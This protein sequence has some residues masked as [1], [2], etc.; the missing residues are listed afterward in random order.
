MQVFPDGQ[1]CVDVNG[2]IAGSATSII[3]SLKPEYRSHSLYE[4][5]GSGH[6]PNG[7]SLYV[8][9]ILT[10]P[11]YRRRG[12]G[13]ALMNARKDLCIKF[14]LRRIIGGGRLS[15]YCNFSNTMSAEKYANLVVIK[16][17][18]DPVLSFD[19]KNGFKFIKILPNY[20]ADQRLLNFASF[21]E[22][23]P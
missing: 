9:D 7:D 1:F 23:K 3:V 11:L 17:L 19:I 21:I 10:H 5:L 18:V 2:T 22:W 13:T 4:I 20:S 16:K 8:D 14:G 12:I 6:N 15:N